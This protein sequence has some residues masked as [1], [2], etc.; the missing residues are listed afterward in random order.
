LEANLGKQFIRP[1]L[2]KKKTPQKRAGAVAQVVVCLPSK[3]EIL[4]SN[5]N[6]AKKKKVGT[7]GLGV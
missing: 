7:P 5:P 2:K 4:S 3:C 1:Y 6:S